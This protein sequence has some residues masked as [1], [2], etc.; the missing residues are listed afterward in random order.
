MIPAFD[1]A[2]TVHALDRAATVIGSHHFANLKSNVNFNSSGANYEY[3]YFPL[4]LA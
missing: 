3:L 4:L 2:K 1:R